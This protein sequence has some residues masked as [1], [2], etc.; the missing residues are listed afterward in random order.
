[1]HMLD[2]IAGVA[3]DFV[4]FKTN[5]NSCYLRRMPFSICCALLRDWSIRVALSS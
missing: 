2:V 3:L 4:E 5:G 1:M